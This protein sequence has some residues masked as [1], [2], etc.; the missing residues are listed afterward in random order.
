MSHDFEQDDFGNII[1]D[2]LKTCTIKQAPDNVCGNVGGIMDYNQ[3]SFMHLIPQ[4][5]F[6]IMMNW[7][8]FRKQLINGR[9]VPK[10][11]F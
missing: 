7:S 9:A 1:R 6:A 3:V 4:M 5:S 10:K 8:V 11:T 2:P